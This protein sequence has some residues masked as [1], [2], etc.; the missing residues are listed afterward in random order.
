MGDPGARG[1]VYTREMADAIGKWTISPLLPRKVLWE[2][3]FTLDFCG[4][5]WYAFYAI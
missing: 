3:H 2:M 4:K 1:I 5:L